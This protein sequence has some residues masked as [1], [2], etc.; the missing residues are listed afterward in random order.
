VAAVENMEAPTTVKELQIFLGQVS[1]YDWFLSSIIHTLLP[2]TN[3]LK[4]G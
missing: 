3:K 4:G 2:L 1:F